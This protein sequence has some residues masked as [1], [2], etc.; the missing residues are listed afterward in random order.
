MLLEDSSPFIRA[1]SVL[2]LNG[3]ETQVFKTYW[4]LKTNTLSE[5]EAEV[6]CCLSC[7]Q[8]ICLISATKHS[9]KLPITE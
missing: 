8:A 2:R 5:S 3:G 4:S 9:D 1:S 7:Y 6:L